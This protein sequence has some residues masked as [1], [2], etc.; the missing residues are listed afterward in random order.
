RDLLTS[1]I[2][3]TIKVEKGGY[4]TIY[5]DTY[6]YPSTPTYFDIEWEVTQ[7]CN[8][9][10]Y[11]HM[12][13]ALSSATVKLIR[14]SDSA[15]LES[16]TTSV[17]GY[18]T[19]SEDVQENL[20]CKIQVEK[21]N[22]ETQYITMNCDEQTTYTN[23]RSADTTV[24]KIAAFFYATDATT[25][26][27]LS[28][29]GD[30]LI[31]DEGFDTV[32][33]FEDEDDWDGY[34]IG[35]IDGNETSEDFVFLYFCGHGGYDSGDDDSW[36]DLLNSG[37]E[38]M[39]SDN[40]VTA[41]LSLES[42]NIFVIVESCHSGG[43]IDD[44]EDSDRFIISTTDKVND[45]YV[46]YSIPN[47]PIFTHNFFERIDADYDDYESYLY[48]RQEAISEHYDQNPQYDDQIAYTWFK[49]W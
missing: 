40:L 39:Y 38:K 41:L 37:T 19:F 2:P 6:L 44:L 7:T 15:V 17:S 14:M 23:F 5:R 18:Y 22:Y 29:Y 3:C 33:Y 31:N 12:G 45:A 32:M 9:Y 4:T 26:A 27:N 16:G 30:Q 24:N 34:I 35:D 20:Y 48:G 28:I 47:D 36:V 8:G 43:F 11:D 25:Y 1:T 10:V 46:Y 21:T 49:W 42:N 13:D